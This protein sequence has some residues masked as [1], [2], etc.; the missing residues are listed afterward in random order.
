M[1]WMFG[2]N[3]HYGAPG[4]GGFY[5]AFAGYRR[6]LVN[7][8]LPA[9]APSYSSEL[10]PK[11][12]VILRDHYP[13]QRE[14]FLHLKHGEH[15]AHYDDDSGSI[16]LYG[17]GRILADEFGYIGAA[18]QDDHSLL[19]SPLVKGGNMSLREFVTTARYDYTAGVKGAWTRQIA[20]V[21]GATAESPCYFLLNDSLRAA[22]PATWRL[23][24]TAAEVKLGPNGATVVGKEDVDM[25][26]FFLA[27]DKVPLKTE[28]RTRRSGSGMFPN[29]NWQAMETTQ[30]GLIADLPKTEGL[31]VL[32]YPRLKTAKRPTVTVLAG[33]KAAKIGHEAGV[34][35]V[36]LG[37]TAF[38]YEEGDIHFS[39]M[40]GM[41]QL[42]D[43]NKGVVMAMGSAGKISARG[44]TVASEKA[45]P[46]TK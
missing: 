22:G 15:N 30:I 5:P 40:A 33:G 29:W 36:F 3:N 43:K 12:G 6:I 13:S 16:I 44:K 28:L 38:A 32:L 31:S 7:A 24:L 42:R 1:Q 10:F 37:N 46:G 20:M 14:T 45:L 34:D 8:D 21:K 23:W 4:I 26:V 41:I 35:Y 17:K 2:Q 19:E 25:D 18:P 11:T 27:P 39:G 9:R